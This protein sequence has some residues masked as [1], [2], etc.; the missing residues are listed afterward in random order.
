MSGEQEYHGGCS[1]SQA[2]G[3]KSASPTRFLLV[4]EVPE[5]SRVLW[6]TRSS[7]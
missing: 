6:L 4:G 1:Q 2:P 3:A 5:I 7:L